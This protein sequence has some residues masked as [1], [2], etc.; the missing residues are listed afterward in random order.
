M[1]WRTSLI[2]YLTEHGRYKN[3]DIIIK[4]TT[5]IQTASE[6]NGLTIDEFI[7]TIGSNTDNYFDRDLLVEYS[8]WLKQYVHLGM[9]QKRITR[10]RR[11]SLI[12]Y[13]KIAP[14][15]VYTFIETSSKLND[16][17]VDKFIGTISKQY[18]INGLQDWKEW[19]TNTYI[20]THNDEHTKHVGDLGIWKSSFIEYIKDKQVPSGAYNFIDK[21]DSSTFDEFVVALDKKFDG[22][23]DGIYEWEKSYLK[24][25]RKNH[26]W[27]DCFENNIH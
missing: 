22:E 26:E 25:Q 27:K 17:S 23:I 13:L 4:Y 14:G 20:S 24:S 16:L 8:Q 12:Q 18:E 21:M 19:Y 10:N 9:N 6:L 1:V 15:D 2:E 3:N 5:F 11:L 7:D